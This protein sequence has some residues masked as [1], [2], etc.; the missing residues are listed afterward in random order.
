MAYTRHKQSVLTKMA[1]RKSIIA[2]NGESIIVWS[3]FNQNGFGD[4][5]VSRLPAYIQAEVGSISKVDVSQ[6]KSAVKN[7]MDELV[8]AYNIVHKCNIDYTKFDFQSGKH[9][10]ECNFAKEMQTT[11]QAITTQANAQVVE[12]VADSGVIA[13]IKEQRKAKVEFDEIR[14]MLTANK[15]NKAQI[16]QHFA[17]A[18]PL[19]TQAISSVPLPPN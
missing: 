18:F 7:T 6:R 17:L 13:W 9:E 10:I 11:S 1:E 12:A 4:G 16:D 2:T 8:K 14:K 15:W 19:P 3:G 5:S